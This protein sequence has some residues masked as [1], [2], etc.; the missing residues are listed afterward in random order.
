VA[1]DALSSTRENKVGKDDKFLWP[2]NMVQFTT[3][4][5]SIHHNFTTF[6]HQKTRWKSQNP[7]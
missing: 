3:F 7:L 2:E 1:A 6:Y 5:P 4:L